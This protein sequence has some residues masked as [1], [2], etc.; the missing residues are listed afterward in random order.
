[1]KL[2]SDIILAMTEYE[3]DVPHR[4]HHFLKVFGFAKSI[5]ELED[6]DNKTQNIVCIAALVHDI[7][8]APSLKKYKSSAGKYQEI[9]GIVPA[10]DLLTKIKVPPDIIERVCFLVAHHH[11][12]ADIR[13][14]DYQILVEADFLVNI[15]EEQFS[16]SAIQN[17]Y[18]KIFVTKSGR[19]LC[20]N[21]YLSD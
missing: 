14:L 16:Y 19:L 11:T 8:I 3:K 21:M 7:G 12:Y 4:V 10:K 5:S 6:V 13:D 9:E 2:Y 15:L 18:N 17:A 20:K 1:M